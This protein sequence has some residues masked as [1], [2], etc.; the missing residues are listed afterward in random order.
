LR[1]TVTSSERLSSR[2]EHRYRILSCFLMARM[3]FAAR[4]STEAFST[5]SIAMSENGRPSFSRR[6]VRLNS[7]FIRRIVASPAW[8]S[9]MT[10][11]SCEKCEKAKKTES[12]FVARSTLR[13]P[14]SRSTRASAPRRASCI[15]NGSS[16]SVRWA[17]AAILAVAFTFTARESS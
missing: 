14:S 13:R 7:V 8:C 6:S 5:A 16:W 17:R 3:V 12:T 15:R 1:S 10:W 4:G 9:E 11:C 2:Y